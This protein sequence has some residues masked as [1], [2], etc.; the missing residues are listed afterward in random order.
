M[1]K[2]KAKLEYCWILVYGF[3]LIWNTRFSAVTFWHCQIIGHSNLSDKYRYETHLQLLSFQNNKKQLLNKQNKHFY[4]GKRI[5]SFQLW[6]LIMFSFLFFKRYSFD[7]NSYWIKWC[8]MN[9]CIKADCVQAQFLN[10]YTFGL[11]ITMKIC[12]IFS[13][14]SDHLSRI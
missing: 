10:Q 1:V 6:I 12:L 7:I 2:I 8:R 11:W 3:I 4:N 9:N 13:K 5:K 14:H